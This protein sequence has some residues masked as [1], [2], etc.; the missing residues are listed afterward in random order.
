MQN[1]SRNT[2]NHDTSTNN[3]V[4]ESKSAL[5]NSEK[6][7][8]VEAIMNDA[9]AISNEREQFQKTIETHYH[10]ELYNILT[11]VYTLYQT[12]CTNN[13]LR[14]V[15]RNMRVELANTNPE[16]KIQKN[17]P[18]ITV[19]VRY[20]FK[21]DRNRAYNYSNTLQA[22]LA[23]D[24]QPKDIAKFIEQG[25]GVEEIKREFKKKDA[26]RTKEEKLKNATEIVIS[27]LKTMKAKHTAEISGPKVK[28]VDDTKYVFIIARDLDNG[29]YEL[30]QTVP[31]TTKGL[32]NLAIKEIAKDNIEHKVA[33]STPKFEKHISVKDAANM[34][35]DDLDK[36][37]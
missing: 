29:V 37:A 1:S 21:C 18:I 23:K 30:L 12:T 13:C 20:V 26:T 3:K 24:I 25:N 35:F 9:T 15:V 8:A 11:K 14:E 28:L 31:K 2:Q 4:E 34:T 32:E 27:E 36:A 5:K 16:I 7:Q 10:K 6:A 19:F 17:T 33:D 22:A